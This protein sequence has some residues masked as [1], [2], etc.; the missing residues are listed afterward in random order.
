M[1]LWWSAD[2]KWYDGE[3]TGYDDD[4][5]H[6]G[7]HT[8]KYDDGEAQCEDLKEMKWRR[9]VDGAER[10]HAEHAA[11]PPRAR[12]RRRR[13]GRRRGRGR[14][15]RAVHGAAGAR[16]IFTVHCRGVDTLKNTQKFADSLTWPEVLRHVV[17]N[18]A[19][20]VAEVKPNLRECE[21]AQ[22]AREKAANRKRGNTSKDID[23]MNYPILAPDPE[24]RRH[25]SRTHLTYT[26]SPTPPIPT[27]LTTLLPPPI[28]SSSSSR[29]S[30][31]TA[32]TTSSR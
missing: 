14:R 25:A 4:A 10:T 7:E 18:W 15:R 22:E 3:V 17:L 8:I 6:P 2:R 16:R 27:P 19:A 21:T 20:R 23:G 12:R 32:T 11:A 13:R 1:R 9:L 5:A 28:I 30:S 29:G 24:V 31:R 26:H